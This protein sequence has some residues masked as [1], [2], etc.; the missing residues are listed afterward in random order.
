[1]SSATMNTISTR[2]FFKG[3]TL[4]EQSKPRAACVVKA[5]SAE[6][7]PAATPP[8]APKCTS[9][10]RV[11]CVNRHSREEVYELFGSRVTFFVH[12]KHL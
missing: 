7:A 9:L 12:V 1:M 5:V 3:T 2:A 10:V 8:P 6:A 4:R 11:T